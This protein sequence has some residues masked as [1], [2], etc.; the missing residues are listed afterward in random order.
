MGYD[1]TFHPFDRKEFSYFI[2]QVVAAPTNYR[3]QVQKLHTDPEEHDYVSNNLY[4]YWEEHTNKIVQGSE[5]ESTL[6]FGIAGILGYLHP[7]W[8]SRGGLLSNLVQRAPFNEFTGQL[9]TL[10]SNATKTIFEKNGGFI[11][12][13]YSSGCYIPYESISD[14]KATL[15]D[16]THT[17]WVDEQIGD[18]N[19]DSL[20]N[21]LT[22]CLQHQL[23]LLECTDLYVPISGECNTLPQ[24]IRA[25]YKKN[26][27]DFSNSGAKTVF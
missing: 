17:A 6:G 4:F 26:L 8:Y 1:V 15:K 14:L 13:N 21:C 10:A 12:S 11:V 27:D 7:Y 9:A 5:F 24:N 18:Y 23:D 2:D 25:G 3:E 22:Y 20:H 16:P 19:I